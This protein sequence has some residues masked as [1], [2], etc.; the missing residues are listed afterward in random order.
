MRAIAESHQQ[1]DESFSRGTVVFL[2]ALSIAAITGLMF[3][4]MGFGALYAA[5]VVVG[6]VFMTTL[7]FQPVLGMIGLLGT[8]LLGL[9]GFLAG[10]GRLT[11]NNLLGLVLLA[12]LLIQVC[13]T[14]NIWFLKTPQVV[15][16]LL[17]GVALLLSLLYARHVYVPAAPPLRMLFLTGGVGVEAKDWTE[18]ILF[19]FW[20]RLAFLVMFVNFVRTRRHVLLILLSLMV[21]TMAVIPSA[22]YN[23][24]TYQGEEDIATGK[25]VDVETGKTTEFRITSE[26]TSW[27]RNENRLAFMCNV[28]ILLIWMFT[29]VFRRVAVRVVAFPL[30]LVMAGL[31][32][33]TAS[34]SGFL[35]LGLVFLFLLFQRGIRWSF[36]FSVIG[37]IVFSA[38]VFFIALPKP[39]YERLTNLSLDQSTHPEAWRST[40][41]RIETN[42]HA[43][44]IFRSAPITGIG[45]GNFR[46]VHRERYPNSIA[47]G[48]PNHNSYLWAAT[49]GGIITLS[50]YLILFVFIWRDLGAAQ[51]RY[52]QDSPLWHI[53]RFLRGFFGLFIFFSVF[54]D[55]WLEPQLYLLAGLSMLL[56]RRELEEEQEDLEPAPAAAVATPVPT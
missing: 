19:T 27:A 12:I 20:S 47:A 35:S 38:L 2:V 34:R 7:L 17:I 37:A 43:L 36:R 31:V 21:F 16:F 11:A 55:F 32:L 40:Q 23:L 53:T 50:L 42:Q 9:P 10:E 33:G 28:T 39:A 46:W 30:I 6:L 1:R 15:L 56:A 24:S 4:T 44:E 18:N 14:R 8:L 54:A 45:P 22:F 3:L 25:T 48:R 52:P 5:V 51:R 29:Q 49:E 26:T 41:S 13:T